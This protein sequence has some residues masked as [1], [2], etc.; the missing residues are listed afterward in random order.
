MIRHFLHIILESIRAVKR[1]INFYNGDN[2]FRL[3]FVDKIK[4]VRHDF[5]LKEYG[6]YQL[7]KNDYRDYLSEHER[8]MF[9]R[10]VGSKRILL[11]YKIIFSQ[12]M[13]NYVPTNEIYAYQIN[14]VYVSLNDSYTQ[15][16]LRSRLDAG[17]TLVYKLENCSG[18]GKSF[19]LLRIVDGI[20]YV[21]NKPESIEKL[22]ELVYGGEDFLIE[23]YCKQSDFENSIF[24]DSVNTLR[25]V[26][27][28]NQ[29]KEVEIILARHRFGSTKGVCVDNAGAGGIFADVDVE[30]GVMQEAYTESVSNIFDET[31]YLRSYTHHPVTGHQI[32]GLEI[33]NWNKIKNQIL[34]LHNTIRFTK[35]EFIAWDIA[36]TNNGIRVIEGNVSCSHDFLQVKEGVRN[37]KFGMWMRDKG[38]I[39]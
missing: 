3:G 7:G 22:G 16:K 39:K 5:T 9:R 37:K 36:I 14:G 17:E 33:P 30:T 12:L 13:R 6:L 32:K 19:F 34:Q 23:E 29:N 31:G 25:L 27:V 4:A 35:L 8:F 15:D 2:P 18:G 11:D 38:Y 20:L 28:I 24:P 26:T 10:A 21:N 1:R